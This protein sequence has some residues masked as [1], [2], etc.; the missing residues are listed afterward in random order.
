MNTTVIP[1]KGEK[2]NDIAQIHTLDN[3]LILRSLP[4]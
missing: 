2:Q 1:F 4:R 3:N